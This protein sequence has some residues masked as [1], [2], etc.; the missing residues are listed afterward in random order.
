MKDLDTPTEKDLDTLVYVKKYLQ[1]KYCDL[2]HL[3]NSWI[4][5]KFRD[6][7]EFRID[8]KNNLLQYIGTEGAMEEHPISSALN[9]SNLELIRHLKHVHEVFK[10]LLDVSKNNQ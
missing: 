3:N 6:K 5:A 1:T 7:A 10:W 9:S 8:P 2:F 4:I